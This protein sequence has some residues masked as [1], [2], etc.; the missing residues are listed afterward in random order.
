MKIVI[1]GGGSGGH[2]Y[3]LISVVDKVRE[4]ADEKNILQ[5]KII[6]MATEPYDED[7]LFK[8]EID[9]VKISAGKLRRS[10]G[11]FAN[12]IDMFKTGWGVLDTLVRMFQIYPDVVFTNGGYVAFPVVVSARILR[13]PVV[14]HVSDTVPSRVLLYAGKFAEKI[15]ICF[16]EAASYFPKEKTAQLGN[17]IRDEIKFKQKDDAHSFFSLS[18]DLKTI[19]VLG[20]SQGSQIINDTVVQA[21][22]DLLRNYQIIHQTGKKN[23]DEV[24]GSSGVVLLDNP[25]K[26]RYKIY[27]YMDD[28]MMKK[29]AGCADLVL[30]RSGAG[31][32]NEIANWGL[33][34]VLIPISKQVSRDQESN[35]FAYARSGAGIVIRQ[36]NL[37]PNILKFEINR[38][39]EDKLIE[40]MQK[41]AKE[42]FIPDAETK[43]ANA[44]IDV[45]VS[46]QK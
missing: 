41:N 4:I 8:N 1:T 19:W 10:G 23:Y 12:I 27:P 40:D 43:I 45:L 15:S 28:L 38:I 39:F 11:F 3:P 18:P 29:A 21:L 37:T 20:G 42:F 32:I 26:D 9:F 46:H 30:M 44:L 6:Y 5:P 14:I 36:K 2:F 7:I 24:Y 33:A 16:Q 31:S 34:S 22:P 17:P 25:H 35:A 13:I